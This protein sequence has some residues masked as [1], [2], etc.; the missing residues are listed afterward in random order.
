MDQLETAL[1]EDEDASPEFKWKT[2]ILFNEL[3]RL[4]ESESSSRR[5][6]VVDDH[7]RTQV[8]LFKSP[9]PGKVASKKQASKAQSSEKIFH[10][11][12]PCCQYASSLAMD[13]RRH[14]ETH[15]PQKRYMCLECANSPKD[16]EMLQCSYC[17]TRIYTLERY[18]V[19]YLHCE[20]AKKN[21][22]TFSRKDKLSEHL[23][24]DHLAPPNSALLQA[25]KWL[26]DIDSGWPRHC[27][28]C[29]VQFTNWDE[30]AKHLIE[31]HFKQ[32]VDIRT[33][34]TLNP[35]EALPP[36]NT[37]VLPDLEAMGFEP[38]HL[39]RAITVKKPFEVELRDYYGKRSDEIALEVQEL[40][41]QTISLHNTFAGN[42]VAG[43][44]LDERSRLVQERFE[45]LHQYLKEYGE[46]MQKQ[47]RRHCEGLLG[48]YIDDTA[49]LG[50]H[51]VEEKVQETRTYEDDQRAKEIVEDYLEA[52]KEEEKQMRKE[53]Q[54]LQE[55]IIYRMQ[56]ATQRART[57]ERMV[58]TDRERKALT[59]KMEGLCKREREEEF[60]SMVDARK[61]RENSGLDV[62]D[63]LSSKMAGM[64]CSIM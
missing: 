36:Q 61:A 42:T 38:V 45:N 53:V 54:R 51:S 50:Q 43:A 56:C 24:K 8:P 10:C 28:F 64:T 23:Q 3:K 55:E 39:S 17:T 46:W 62:V 59:S 44:R 11:T 52:L 1:Q 12:S 18:N 32:G 21:A 35:F 29:Y 16:P 33:W 57:R 49:S 5:T 14:E 60:R 9:R 6:R 15:W 25:A 7:R 22:R 47:L 34:Q 37:S 58:R 2:S 4:L 31:D 19:H 27:G 63:S 20:S 13:W 48:G 41:D 30:R 26:F 40:L